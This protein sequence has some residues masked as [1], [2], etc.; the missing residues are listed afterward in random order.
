MIT[1]TLAQAPQRADLFGWYLGFGIGLLVVVVVAVL[2]G[3][4]LFLAL[5]IG[6]YAPM[7]DEALQQAEHNTRALAGLKTTIDHATVIVGGL[8]RGRARLGG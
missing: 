4:I 2:V 1:S 7:I 6:K 5:K 8:S 3:W